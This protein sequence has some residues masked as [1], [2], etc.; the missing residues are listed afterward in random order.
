MATF[1]R[2][3]L[4]KGDADASDGGN[5]LQERLRIGWDTS[6]VEISATPDKLAGTK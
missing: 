3:S 1:D 2:G 6:H 5:R 4:P